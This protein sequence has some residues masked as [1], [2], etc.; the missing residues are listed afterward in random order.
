MIDYA[1]RMETQI[2]WELRSIAAQ[3]PLFLTYAR[4]RYPKTFGG[5]VEFAGADT[6]DDDTDIVIEG[7][8]RSGNT[9]A[10]TAFKVAQEKPVNVANHLHAPAQLT[11]AADKGIPAVVLMRDP[12]DAAVS[13]IIQHDFS[14]TPQ[15]VFEQYVRFHEAIDPVRGD[16][17]VAP[18]EQVISDFGAVIR[19]VNDRFGCR[20]EIFEHSRENEQY[21]FDI[22]ERDSVKRH[23]GHVHEQGVARPSESREDIKDRLRK[24]L[25][26]P[27]LDSIRD[28]AYDLYER[29]LPQSAAQTA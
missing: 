24:Q 16:L 25:R 8:P 21:C 14:L 11:V 27:E 19:A 9:F 10:V 23:G 3:Y 4:W 17:Y 6:V 1:R 22:I 28:R 26:M 29:F 15:Q 12:E 13:F 2:R 20:F 18:F 7:F 5:D